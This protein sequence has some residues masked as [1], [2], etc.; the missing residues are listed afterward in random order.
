MGRPKE[1]SYCSLRCGNCFRTPDIAPE[2]RFYSCTRCGA[3][4]YECTT[5]VRIA[6]ERGF[7]GITTCATCS[8]REEMHDDAS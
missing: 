3:P 7:A 4:T 5:C 1:R 6:E 8:L 2:A